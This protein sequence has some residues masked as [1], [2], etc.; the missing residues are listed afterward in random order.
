MSASD[1]SLG[2]HRWPFYPMKI[3]T[4]PQ[5]TATS[6]MQSC[7]NISTFNVQ[8]PSSICL[9][10]SLRKLVVTFWTVEMFISKTA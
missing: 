4:A 9:F 7:G 1:W 2:V 6:V 10:Q 3:H 5:R 8:C